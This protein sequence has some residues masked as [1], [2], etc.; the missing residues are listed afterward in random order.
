MEFFSIDSPVM[1]FLNKVADM[2][3]LNIVFII[4][5]IPVITIGASITALYSTTLKLI[6]DEEDNIIKNFIKSFKVN[7]KISTLIEL[8]IFFIVSLL[9]VDYK[10]APAFSESIE[11]VIKLMIISMTFFLVIAIIYI[12]PYISRF[13]NSL[14]ISIKNSVLIGILNLPKTLLIFS[15]IIIPILMTF[16]LGVEFMIIFWLLIGFSLIGYLTSMHFKKI[17]NIYEI[18]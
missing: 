10:I 13:E 16:V 17:F 11:K 8:I 1:D 3:I 2:I 18:K 12:F 15:I 9:I 5:C 14:K 7:F 4:C 6:S